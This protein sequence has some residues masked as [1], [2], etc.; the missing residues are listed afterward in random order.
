M[1]EKRVEIGEV[2]KNGSSRIKVAV[3]EYKEKPYA[4]IRNYYMD[5]HDEWQPTKKGVTFHTVE[6]LDA[7]IDLLTKARLVLAEM[8]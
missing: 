3:A 1:A 5:D 6:E 7:A 8:V 2:K 4:D